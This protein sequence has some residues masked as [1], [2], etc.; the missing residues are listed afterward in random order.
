MNIEPSSASDCS[1]IATPRTDAV[2]NQYDAARA[3]MLEKLARQLERELT[4]VKAAMSGRTVS[5]ENCNVLTSAIINIY[6]WTG[7]RRVA[8]ECK[9]VMPNVAAMISQND[10]GVP[11]AAGGTK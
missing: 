5:C 11:A 7:S 10:Q 3:V 2:V 1:V 9:R 8:R 6:R 4:E